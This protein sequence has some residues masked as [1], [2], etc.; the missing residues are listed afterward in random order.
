MKII[1][2]EEKYCSYKSWKNTEL[3]HL[4]DFSL[5]FLFSSKL[6]N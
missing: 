2:E 4:K 3:S 5:V 6:T 1:I